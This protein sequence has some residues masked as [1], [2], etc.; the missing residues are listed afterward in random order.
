MCG[1]LAAPILLVNALHIC[2]CHAAPAP[3]RTETLR[4][5]LIICQRFPLA[6]FN[7]DQIDKG[8][9]VYQ[10][11]D[12][13]LQ[14]SKQQLRKSEV[15]NNQS[16]SPHSITRLGSDRPRFKTPARRPR[17]P[18]NRKPLMKLRLRTL[19]NSAVRI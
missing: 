18:R 15:A 1:R 8:P 10:Q 3:L 6:C 17:R 9:P 4:Y 14:E 12:A 7:S 5:H 16:W 19:L 2:V 11:I 13:E